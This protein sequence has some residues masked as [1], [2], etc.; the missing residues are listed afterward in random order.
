MDRPPQVFNLSR[1]AGLQAKKSGDTRIN[2]S[3][4]WWTVSKLFSGYVQVCEKEVM[5]VTL[6]PYGNLLMG[7]YRLWN[8]LGLLA[9][10]VTRLSRFS[11]ESGS[12]SSRLVFRSYQGNILFLI[13]EMAE[14]QCGRANSKLFIQ[15]HSHVSIVLSKGFSNKQC[16]ALNSRMRFYLFLGPVLMWVSQLVRISLHAQL[17]SLW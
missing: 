7:N 11:C 8:S 4:W 15:R 5:E 6:K 14:S 2:F 17:V 3:S 13:L 12:A 9:P 16:K 1:R 10:S